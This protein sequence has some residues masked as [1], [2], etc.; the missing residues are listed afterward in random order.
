[1]IIYLKTYIKENIK[2]FASIFA[3]GLMMAAI[4]L[5][6]D[7]SLSEILYGILVC[8]FIILVIAGI[9][10][11]Q[12]YHY[13]INLE[14]LKNT[15]T[16]STNGMPSPKHLYELPYQQCIK[17]LGQEK[18]RVQNELLDRQQDLTEYYSMWVHQIKTPIAALK[19][20]LDE[21]KHLNTMSKDDTNVINT[22]KKQQ[23]LFKIEQYVDMAL[24]YMRLGS[25]SN[26]F[27]FEEVCL[28][29]VV[30]PSIR[31]FS[32]QFIHKKL[33]LHYEPTL[34]TAVTDKKWLGFVLEQLLSN[35]I[36][37]TKSGG[38]T[39]TVTSGLYDAEL[40]PHY[41]DNPAWI[42]KQDIDT[43]KKVCITI[44]DTGIGIRAEDLPRVCEKGY[45]GYNG[46]EGMHSTGIGL[47]LC[48]QILDK[49]GH[50]LLISSIEGAGTKAEV[51]IVQ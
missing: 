14:Q 1:M 3:C 25:K 38:I 13:C 26:D 46:H 39:I 36:K 10:F 8:V 19:L 37:Y 34:I 31:K 15:I 32:K 51:V 50:R 17:Q 40:L 35:A 2:W 11:Y 4:L 20:L 21:E 22:E 23:E 33:A 48:K 27:V 6:N 49:L 12:Y 9:D 16:I 45:T 5:L 44:E 47:Y 41:T 29:A 7:I 28:D 42:K 30:K 18:N 43:Y 24:Q